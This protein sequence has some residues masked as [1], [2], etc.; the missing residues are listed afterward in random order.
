MPDDRQSLREQL[1]ANFDSQETADSGTPERTEQ[2]AEVVTER[3]HEVQ[4]AGKAV[5]SAGVKTSDAV[6]GVQVNSEPVKGKTEPAKEAEQKTEGPARG[7]DGKF[8]AKKY[9]GTWKKELEAHWTKPGGHTPEEWAAIQS[10]IERRESEHSSNATGLQKRLAEIET[11]SKPF[12]EIF[13]PYKET[14]ARRG[15]DP[16]ALTKQLLA[17]AEFADRD[18]AGFVTEQARMRGLD[19][20]SL[21]QQ[22]QDSGQAADPRVL[23]LETQLR[24][25]QAQIQGG[26]QQAQQ[27][28]QSQVK[29]EV[30]AFSQATNQDGSPKR[31]HFERVKPLMGRLLAGDQTLT[32]EQAYDQACYADP[33][34]RQALLQDEWA[35]REKKRLE[36]LKRIEDAAKSHRGSTN[37]REA[38]PLPKGS[39]LRA[40][41]SHAYDLEAGEARVA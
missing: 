8:V 39:T 7:A 20:A 35:Q 17:M 4:N 30:D 10:E 1:A 16:A 14:F 15:I 22:Q 41:L 6:G 9:P 37:G 3:P 38:T 24:T 33:E 5:Q 23:Q 27:H 31:P 28:V 25:L 32:L 18:F 2:R 19:L 26:Q 34:I 40:Q 11:S 12:N 29:S 13:A 36:D 21:V